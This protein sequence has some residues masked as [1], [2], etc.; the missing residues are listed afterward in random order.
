MTNYSD[1]QIKEIYIGTPTNKEWLL[2]V[3]HSFNY[4]H[5]FWK[6]MQETSSSY[7]RFKKKQNIF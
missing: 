1:L 7:S 2:S 5:G 3:P 4:G 6:T